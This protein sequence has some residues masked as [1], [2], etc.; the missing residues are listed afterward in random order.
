VYGWIAEGMPLYKALSR[1]IDFF[2]E[3]VD[4][5]LI[6]VSRTEAGSK[7][8]RDMPTDHLEQE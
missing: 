8:N 2:P 1:A 3:E 4:I 6:A 7:S 5:G